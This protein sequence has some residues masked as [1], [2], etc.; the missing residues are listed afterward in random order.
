MSNKARSASGMANFQS[1]RTLG[2]SENCRR[3]RFPATGPN[4]R[5]PGRRPAKCQRNNYR[6]GDELLR[7]THGSPLA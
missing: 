3:K 5:G 1:T 4:F 7:T 6:I 2:N